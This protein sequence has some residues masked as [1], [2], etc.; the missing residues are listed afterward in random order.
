MCARLKC[1]PILLPG[2][3]NGKESS[4]LPFFVESH[5]KGLPC[6][7]CGLCLAEGTRGRSP[8]RASLGDRPLP[9][10]YDKRLRLLLPVL[11]TPNIP[12]SFA[13]QVMRNTVG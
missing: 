8:G 6:T 1:S 5:T 7:S 4:I 2:K 11:N 10:S 12:K 13:T 9:L 3:P